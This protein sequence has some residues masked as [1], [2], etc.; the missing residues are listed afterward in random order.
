MAITTSGL[1]VL[2]FRD[3]LDTSNL[4]ID[5][6]LTTHKF[7]LFNDTVAPNFD[8]DT[9][10]GVAPYNANEVSGGAGWPS[11]GVA[12]SAAAAGSTS[13]APT[14]GLGNAGQ[15]KYDM[16]DVSVANTS[17]TSAMGALLYADALA[18]NEAICL[19][20]FVTAATT[21]SGTFGITWDAL[22]VFTID[23]VP[24]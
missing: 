19:I 23:L 7:A 16:G 21:S 22:G 20:D 18:G 8:T 4:G 11:G 2:T 6:L 15:L 9:A 1:Y 3:A 24:G 12:L 13:T 5:L 17:L 14:W 10:Y